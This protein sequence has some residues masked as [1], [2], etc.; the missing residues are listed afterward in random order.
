M[1]RSFG[2][3]S[4]HASRS[5]LSLLHASASYCPTQ[6]PKVLPPAQSD[7]LRWANEVCHEMF[8][9]TVFSTFSGG[10][11]TFGLILL[12]G[13][14]APRGESFCGR[15]IPMALL[16][17]L[18]ICSKDHHRQLWAKW[19]Q[20]MCAR[21]RTTGRLGQRLQLLFLGLSFWS[22][23]S[24]VLESSGYTS[25]T[26]YHTISSNK[27]M[28]KACTVRIHLML[29]PCRRCRSQN[30]NYDCWT[31]RIMYM[32]QEGRNPNPFASHS[33]KH[34]IKSW[35]SAFQTVFGHT[36]GCQETNHKETTTISPM[37]VIWRFSRTKDNIPTPQ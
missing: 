20:P 27:S 36:L 25:S 12:S 1:S 34:A 24:S 13:D 11:A 26:L 33:I 35:I 8:E 9:D 14:D 22:S 4:Q 6:F 21:K 15:S 2:S 23:E 5:G 28:G 17:L 3:P 37:D 32:I 19:W 31:L 18:Q 16:T 30:W 10:S 29:R 7:Q